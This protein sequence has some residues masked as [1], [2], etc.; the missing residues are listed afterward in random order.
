MDINIHQYCN[1]NY[2]KVNGYVNWLEYGDYFT[3]YLKASN[4]TP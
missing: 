3:M 4:C 2:P 1:D